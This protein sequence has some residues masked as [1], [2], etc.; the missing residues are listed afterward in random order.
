MSAG[1]HEQLPVIARDEQLL[2]TPMDESEPGFSP[3]DAVALE[4]DR[5]LPSTV[6]G[7]TPGSELDDAVMWQQCR[8]TDGEKQLRHAGIIASVRG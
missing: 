5:E 7:R 2:I 1:L 3:D 6:C 4:F 8:S